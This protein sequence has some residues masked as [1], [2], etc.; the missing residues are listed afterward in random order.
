MEIISGNYSKTK[1]I[2]KN[3]YISSETNSRYDIRSSKNKPICL[4]TKK[5]GFYINPEKGFVLVFFAK[6]D[7]LALF[8]ERIETRIQK[9]LCWKR[10]HNKGSMTEL[11]ERAELRDA[12]KTQNE[13]YFVRF[14]CL[15]NS[16]GFSA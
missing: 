12:P 2:I 7:P 10:S 1:L 13:L 15:R 11:M 3:R 4:Q 16:G 8:F 6:E 9:F 14:S 5:I